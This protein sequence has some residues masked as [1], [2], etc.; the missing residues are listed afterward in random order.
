[1][2][3][4]PSTYLPK[5]HKKWDGGEK[6]IFQKFIKNLTRGRFL[7]GASVPESRW[8]GKRLSDDLQFPLDPIPGLEKFTSPNI[9][10]MRL[11]ALNGECSPC[12]RPPVAVRRERCR[13]GLALPQLARQGFSQRISQ[14]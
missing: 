8:Q 2:A 6:R 13:L 9:P 10:G 5:G 7:V 14:K 12:P 4:S 1:M 11:H 3:P